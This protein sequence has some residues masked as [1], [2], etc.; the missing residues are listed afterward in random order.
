MKILFGLLYSCLILIGC[1]ACSDDQD[2]Y[3]GSSMWNNR[4]INNTRISILGDSFSSFQYF[5]SPSDNKVWYP[6]KDSLF[7]NLR[8]VEQTWW[9]LT[10]QKYNA[11]LEVNNSYSGSTICNT[12][13]DGY[14]YSSLSFVTR[15]SSIGNPDILFIMGGT[16]DYWAEAPMGNFKY[17]D[18]ITQDL[19]QF[20]P[21][22]AYML[23]YLITKHPNMRIINIIDPKIGRSII[24]SQI[25]ICTHY[26]VDYLLLSNYERQNGHP[27]IK[28]MESIK[29]QIVHFL[30]SQN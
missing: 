25:I 27:N 23:D 13:Y 12:G 4:P 14:D 30:D 15:M 7:N 1:S 10:L 8:T 20:R 5:M 2:E 22:F 26:K 3:S 29:D 11:T 24:N 17:A 28:G 18:W 9:H 6:Q 19:K 16:N 21:A